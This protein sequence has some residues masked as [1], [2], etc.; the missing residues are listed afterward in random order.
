MTRATPG[1]RDLSQ[2]QQQIR[3]DDAPDRRIQT[4]TSGSEGLLD[5]VEKGSG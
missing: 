4:R 3:T 2:A 1:S 5:R